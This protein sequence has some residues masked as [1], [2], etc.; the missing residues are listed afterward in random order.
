LDCRAKLEKGGGG[1]VFF[2]GVKKLFKSP[3][4][5]ELL[6]MALS[7]KRGIVINSQKSETPFAEGG[8]AI[9]CEVGNHP[10]N[11]NRERPPPFDRWCGFQNWFSEFIPKT[12]QRLKGDE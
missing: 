6:C 7:T 10:V 9:R 8:G 2:L 5:V 1:F 12:Y 11:K 3:Q 4:R